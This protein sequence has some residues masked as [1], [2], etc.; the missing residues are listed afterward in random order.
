MAQA[1]QV[2]P[3][4][5][6]EVPSMARIYDCLLGGTTNYESDRAAVKAML[7]LAPELLDAASAN[8]SFHQRAARWVA[9]HGVRQFIDLGSGLP[10]GGNTHQIVLSVAPDARV[11][12]VDIDP[13]VLGYSESLLAGDAQVEA[14]VADIRDVDSVLGSD[15]VRRLID[16]SEPVAI[17]VTGVMHFVPD[18]QDPAGIIARYMAP[19]AAGSY[20]VLSHMTVDQKPPKALEVITGEGRT[21]PGGGGFFRTRD[22]VRR[23]FG[24]LEIIRPYEGAEPDITWVGLWQCEDPVE[25][26]SDGSRWLYCAVARKTS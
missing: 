12:Y 16:F 18:E 11:V 9:E 3:G 26:D 4:V 20:L 21:S 2:P 7:N 17:L 1:R 24:D 13:L 6:P 14:M 5:D 15:V 25:A 8:R 23:L 10:T 19:L 22:E